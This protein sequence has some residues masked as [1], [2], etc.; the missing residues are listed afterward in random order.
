[1]PVA[2]P[3][4]EQA[5]EAMLDRTGRRAVPIRRAFIQSEKPD[6]AGSRGALLARMVHTRDVAALDAYLLIHAM[7]SSEPFDTE[8]PAVSW[9]R[10]LD[11]DSAATPD[12]A[13]GHWAKI[14]ARLIELGLIRR[15]RR[16]NRMAYVLLHEDGTGAEYERPKTGAD[17]LW[18]SLPHTYWTLGHVQRL[19][20]PEKAMLLVSL[21]QKSRFTLPADRAP[22][23]YGISAATA[24]R[25]LTGLR[26][27]GLLTYDTRWRLDAKSTTGWAEERGYQL[28]DSFALSA[29]RAATREKRTRKEPTYFEPTQEPAWAPSS[30]MR[31]RPATTSSLP[32]S[33]CPRTLPRTGRRSTPFA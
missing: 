25:G 1:M 20:L 28:L 3:S 11:L 19:T 29:R 12:A 23:W 6:A 14:T 27:H 8:Y 16:G 2:P 33:C 5:V 30:S 17:G 24:A 7:A 10:A 32:R 4:R 13:R 18:F 21:D 9:V 31:A 26:Q 22:S 15:E